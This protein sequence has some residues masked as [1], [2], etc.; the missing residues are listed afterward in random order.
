MNKFEAFLS[1]FEEELS[2]EYIRSAFKGFTDE[3]KC[4]IFILHEVSEAKTIQQVYNSYLVKILEYLYYLRPITRGERP[5]KQYFI[6][7]ALY[8]PVKKPVEDVGWI[9]SDI[10]IQTIPNLKE[11]ARMSETKKA[12]VI[13]KFLTKNNIRPPST[14]KIKQV[15][16]DLN[17]QNLVFFTESTSEKIGGYWSLNPKFDVILNRIQEVVKKELK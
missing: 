17:E 9:L 2:L 8:S 10:H 11:L 14:V 12:K 6:D 15:L 1:R 4:V 5:I 3:Q 13:Y 7:F 16:L